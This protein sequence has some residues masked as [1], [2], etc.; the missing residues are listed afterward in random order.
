MKKK[1]NFSLFEDFFES[2]S[3][4]DYAK[5]LN[6]KNRGENKEIVKELK[7]RILDLEDRIEKMSEK[8]KNIKMQ[9]RH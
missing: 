1:I 5:I 6:T 3:A 8:E 2:S 7:N 4:A 9:M